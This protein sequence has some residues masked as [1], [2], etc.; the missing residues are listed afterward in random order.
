MLF[1]SGI[2]EPTVRRVLDVALRFGQLLLGSQAGTADVTSS[3]VAVA[4]AYG[5]PDTQVDITANSI[6]VSVPRGVPG[7][8]VTAMYLVQ[9]RS[10]DYTRLQLTTDLAQHVVDTTPEP[11]WVQQQLDTLERA[12]HPYPR[13]VATVAWA[14]MAAGFSVLIGAGALVAAISAATT[15]LIDRVGRILN[16]WRLPFLFQQVV[17]AALATSVAIGL[18]AVGWLP[19]DTPVSPVVAANI[20]VLLSGLATVGSV[21]DA[22]TGYQ[23]TAV[24]REMDILLSSAGILVG[25]S[26]A[27]RTGRALGVPVYVSPVAP[28]A[29]LSVPV[30]LLAGAIGAAAAAIAGYAPLRAASAA[31]IAGAT[32]TLLF[33]GLQ[34]IQANPIVSS[35][36]AAAATG[37][38]GTLLAPRLRVP[39]LVIIM[40]GIVPLVPGLTLFRGFVQ[41]VNGQP[42]AG[43][44]LGM[45]A[46]LALALGAGA[47]LGPL[48]APSVQRELG[49]YRRRVRGGS[50]REVSY[51]R[52]PQLAGIRYVGRRS[53]RARS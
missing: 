33:F 7:A 22:I 17:A 46:G 48:L 52:M 29:A 5:L 51:L 26:I 37:L 32:A 47:V 27:V 6:T 20:V 39:P 12:E 36:A 49:R 13:W 2:D 30:Y 43:G 53:A 1:Q 34:L 3:I 21:Q 19:A 14:V 11:E 25:V 16:G 35:F 50:R 24:S 23:L 31:G 38:V 44:T 18:H 10:L 4:T 15:A 40:A 45:A 42:T 41:L 8:P 9:S 28:V